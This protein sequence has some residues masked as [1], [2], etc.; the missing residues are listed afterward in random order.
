MLEIKKH[1]KEQLEKETQAGYKQQNK[2][3]QAL[4]L[5]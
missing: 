4:N 5:A 3:T 2:R 1:E